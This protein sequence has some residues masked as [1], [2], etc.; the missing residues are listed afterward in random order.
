MFNIHYIIKYKPRGVETKIIKF[1]RQIFFQKPL[2]SQVYYNL[3]SFNH[4][5][6]VMF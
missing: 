1:R 6:S 2:V 3:F 5:R 4:S